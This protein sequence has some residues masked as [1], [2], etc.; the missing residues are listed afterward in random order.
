MV[1]IQVLFGSESTSVAGKRFRSYFELSNETS[2]QVHKTS[3]N[4]VWCYM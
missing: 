1:F 2:R 4:I 3:V